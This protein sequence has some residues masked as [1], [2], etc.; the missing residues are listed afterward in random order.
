[1]RVWEQVLVSV[2]KPLNKCPVEGAVCVPLPFKYLI[3][4]Q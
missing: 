1:M 3:L 2:L 4:E